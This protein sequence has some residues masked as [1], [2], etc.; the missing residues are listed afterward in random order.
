MTDPTPA[1][2][3]I[4]E[5]HTEWDRWGG[6]TAAQRR[7]R[8]LDFIREGVCDHRS[9]AR[10]YQWCG[11]AMAWFYRATLHPEI[12]KHLCPSTYRLSVAGRYTTDPG[13]GWPY[14]YGRR[15][16]QQAERITDYHVGHGGLRRWWTGASQAT[17]VL[18]GD[19]ALVGGP[20]GGSG[21]HIV[22]V[23]EVDADPEWPGV[24]TLSGNGWGT[25]SDGSVGAGVVRNHYAYGDLRRVLRWAP[26]D[27]DSTLIYS[28]ER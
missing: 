13:I 12:R 16:G 6:L 7:D 10:G 17:G 5:A 24:E 9:S 2:R 25:R 4:V 20:A 1:E 3:S 18:P 26:A 23:V 8:T 11:A 27:F 19:V 14:P 15:P 28:V 22:L 21:R